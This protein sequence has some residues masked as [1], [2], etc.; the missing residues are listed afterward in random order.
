VLGSSGIEVLNLQTGKARLL[1]IPGK[2]PAWSP[3]GRHIAYVRD[4]QVLSLADLTKERQGEHR[5]FEQEEIWVAPV[6]GSEAPRFLARGGW[7]NWSADS[8]RVYYHS[9]TDNKM[10]CLGIDPKGGGQQEV[11]ESM[12]MFPFVS[13]D[14]K[15]AAL[16][17][18]EAT[19]QIVDLSKRSVVPGWS[20]P[21]DRQ[22][23]FLSWSADAT[24][25]IV[26][27]YNGGGLWIYDIHKKEPSKVLDGSYGWCTW[28][29][30][31]CRRMA[32]EKDYAQWHHEI[33]V[34]DR[35]LSPRPAASQT[36]GTPE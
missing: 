36:R 5:P 35:P 9:R 32:I 29:D 1:I 10:Y 6:D 33:W 20:G 28:S 2:D 22:Q 7:P 3:D 31:T 15:Y 25:L 24:R 13:P 16:M 27:C 4:R 17:T 8:A 30:A 34:T 11:I 21:T 12:D 18:P 23:L 14:G 19:L 26:G